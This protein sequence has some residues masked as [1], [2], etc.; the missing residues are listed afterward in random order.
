MNSNRPRLR[1]APSPTGTL[2]VGNARTAIFNHLW[3]KSLGGITVLRIEDTDKERS[4]HE[5]EREIIE[6][7]SWLGVE[8][9][10]GPDCG[11]QHGPY[12][13]SQR[14]EI[15]REK[16]DA[17]L[18]S[19]VA[20]RCFCTQERLDKLRSDQT[21]VGKP[22]AYDAH[23]RKLSAEESAEMAKEGKPFCIRFRLPEGK[24]V[25][26]DI[27]RG[28]ME[29]DSSALGGDF[30][31]ARTGGGFTYNFACAIDDME[32]K[33]SHVLRGEDHLTNTAR[34]VLIYKA[35]NTDIPQFAHANLILGAD[36]QKLSKRHGATTIAELKKAGYLPQALFNFLT[37]LGWSP[38]S[39]QEE[40]SQVELENIFSA[41]RLSSSPAVFNYEKLDWLNSRRLR[42]MDD[43]DYLQSARDFCDTEND[44]PDG[45]L[46]LFKEELIKFSDLPEKLSMI[47]GSL[48]DLPAEAEEA[49]TWQETR[50]VIEATLSLL[51]KLE[52]FTQE[53][54][55][56]LLDDLKALK[57]AKGKKLFW[58]LRLA[59][60][61]SVR[62]PQL[63]E[64]LYL[65]GCETLRKRL[66][67][68]LQKL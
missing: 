12:R 52:E 28:Q 13:Q 31:I 62:G 14:S 35:F 27:V 55:S 8:F 64:I 33:I 45:A 7:L 6:N 41:E 10:E 15:Y 44:L 39:E 36:R 42:E 20:Y 37:L 1:F 3:A 56:K 49:L 43:K 23:C 22:P 65:I 53:S 40:F 50:P 17:L 25:F 38:G 18:S 9:D 24:A 48:P 61:G 54:V 60:S 57:L 63:K 66:V 5:Y 21:S 68:F 59:A 29:F 34:Q 26:S 47:H 51:D 19:G 67:E 30:I 4:K 46:L 32:M 58:P 16:M 11:G 2:H